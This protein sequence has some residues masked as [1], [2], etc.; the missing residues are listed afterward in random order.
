MITEK[1]I[2]LRTNHNKKL[3]CDIFIHIQPPF[4]SG[5]AASSV[6]KIRTA[7]RSHEPV[8]A[9]IIDAVHQP[10][11]SLSSTFIYL[12]HG[13]QPAEFKD[14]IK[15]ADPSISEDTVLAVYFYK[16]NNA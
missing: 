4:R 5:I 15:K 14:M 10:L 6:F 13:M 11:Y 3:D 16:K 8:T 12:S 9:R 1:E 7:D 2:T